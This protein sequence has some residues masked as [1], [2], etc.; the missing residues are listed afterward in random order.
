MERIG[1]IEMVA[2]V[3]NIKSNTLGEK[4]KTIAEYMKENRKDITI[5]IGGDKLCQRQ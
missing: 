3:G 5:T 1:C 4:M 2:S